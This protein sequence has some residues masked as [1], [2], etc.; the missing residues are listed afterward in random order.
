MKLRLFFSDKVHT[1]RLLT[2]KRGAN[3][4]Y[5]IHSE[6]VASIKTADDTECK[7]TDS[8][9]Y[10]E[11]AEKKIMEREIFVANLIGGSTCS[12]TEDIRSLMGLS[13]S[14]ENLYYLAKHE[15]KS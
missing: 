8:N 1:L 9:A 6:P 13:M 12:S 5:K 4:E 7:A 10:I 11:L 15:S 3:S 14:M 2:K